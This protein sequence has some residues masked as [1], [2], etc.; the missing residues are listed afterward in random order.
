ML[1][2][3]EQGAPIDC[4]NSKGLTP[5]HEAVQM[6]NHDIVHLLVKLGAN[7]HYPVQGSR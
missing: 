4:T 5:L 2:I 7:V 6:G 3:L 1:F